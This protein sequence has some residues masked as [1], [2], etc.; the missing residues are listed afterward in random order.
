MKRVMLLGMLVLLSIGL[1]GCGN[2]DDE[3]D[4]DVKVYEMT[5]IIGT[6]GYTVELQGYSTKYQ[7]TQREIVTP[8]DLDML[9]YELYYCYDG[10]TQ[11]ASL[12]AFQ[13]LDDALLWEESINNDDNFD[14]LFLREGHVILL[15][16]SQ[17]IID[18]F[19]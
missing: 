17:D 13:E 10:E 12:A 9:I 7:F 3:V 5:T 14:S 6:A 19:K 16:D 11:V 1:F 18:L 2:A 4:V 8:Y 15:T